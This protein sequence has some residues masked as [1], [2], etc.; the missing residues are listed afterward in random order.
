MM[1]AKAES[2]AAGSHTVKL[3]SRE[4][5]ETVQKLAA[6]FDEPTAADGSALDCGDKS[7]LSNRQRRQVHPA[8]QL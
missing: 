1:A 5:D 7:P 3:T 8:G 2:T 4:W 6:T